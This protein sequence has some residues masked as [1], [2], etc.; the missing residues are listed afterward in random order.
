MQKGNDGLLAK[1]QPGRLIDYFGLPWPI[2]DV[3]SH[4]GQLLPGPLF[5]YSH[6]G[7]FLVGNT[8]A[9]C[10]ACCFATSERKDRLDP[11]KDSVGG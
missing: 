9:T 4:R 2:H 6:D 1:A 7:L 5:S 3:P 10:C 8:V 11:R